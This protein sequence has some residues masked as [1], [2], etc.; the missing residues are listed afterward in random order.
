MN[1]KNQPNSA[2]IPLV[3][4]FIGLIDGSPLP[5]KGLIRRAY[6]SHGTI[7]RWRNGQSVSRLYEMLE[8]LDV[9]GY[10]LAI[11]PKKEHHADLLPDPIPQAEVPGR[12]QAGQ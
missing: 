8:V 11:M 4:A 10:E 6:I 1:R 12:P 7:P 3:R 2:A 9:L 5:M